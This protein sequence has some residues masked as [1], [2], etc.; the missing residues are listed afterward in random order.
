MKSSESVILIGHGSKAAG[1]DRAMKRVAT[2]LGRDGTRV[3]CAYL[4]INKPSIPDAIEKAVLT[5]AKEIRLLPYFLLSGRHTK[6]HIPD[7]VKKEQ[8]RFGK[9]V[10]IKLRPYLGYDKRIV[11]VVRDRLRGDIS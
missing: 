3:L 2:E 4:E 7:I 6:E 9:K 1:F 8:R 10:K 5:G 11:A